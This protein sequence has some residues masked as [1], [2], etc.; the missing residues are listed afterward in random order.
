MTK[1]VLCFAMLVAFGADCY[2]AERRFL[3]AIGENRGRVDQPPLEYAEQDAE[4]VTV[5]MQ[6]VGGVTRENTVLLR[7]TSAGGFTTAL[8]SVLARLRAEG[9]GRSDLL[10]VYVS[11]HAAEGELHLQG[12]RFPMR[13]LRAFVEDAPV[14][15]A[16]LVVDTCN[17]AWNSRTKGLEVMESRTV[18][19]EQAEV[20]GR[21]FIAS[22]GPTES[23]H[24]SDGFGGSWFT[25]HLIAALRGAGDASHDG[26]VTLQEAFAYAYNRTVESSV[27]ARGGHQTPR[28][29]MQLTGERDVVLS[30]PARGRGLLSITVERPGDWVAGPADGDGPSQRFVKGAGP[31]DFAVSPGTWRVRTT[32]GDYDLEGS[33]LI[34]E[35]GVAAVDE[36]TLSGWARQR[37]RAKGQEIRWVLGAGGQV[38]TP[39]VSTSV[40]VLPGVEVFGRVS[41]PQGLVGTTFYAASAGYLRGT[42]AGVS[43]FPE[44]EVSFALS[45]GPEGWFGPLVLRAGLELG[46][47]LVLQSA[48]PAG[49]R[50]AVVPRGGLIGGLSL[51]VGGPFLF[52]FRLG[53]GAAYV[54]TTQGEHIRAHGNALLGLGVGL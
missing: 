18:T 25:G 35:G 53:G 2:A 17:A 3:V 10:F 14:G 41:D 4:A 44:H 27:G 52:E 39:M 21:V 30:E 54:E 31:V 34:P 1:A 46:G 38:G 13:T 9:W 15:V 37:S 5:A 26:R 51:P 40:P 7:G 43:D 33:V 8:A 28:F 24:E 42:G 6:A 47:V 16:V 12:T 20:A 49:D 36:T 11:G 45:A 19:V 48:S 32:L 22:S 29:E 23:A 50:S